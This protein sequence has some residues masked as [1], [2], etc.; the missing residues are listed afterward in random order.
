MTEERYYDLVQFL[1][2]AF[3][4]DWPDEAATP[5]EVIDNFIRAHSPDDRAHLAKVA[6]LVDAFSAEEPNDESLKRALF[7]KLGC[8]YTPEAD[9]IPTRDWLRHVSDRLREASFAN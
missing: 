1:A 8:Y 7:K 5:D 3:N 4:E 2:G 6:D 9:A